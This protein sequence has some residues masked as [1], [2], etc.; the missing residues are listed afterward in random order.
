MTAIKTLAGAQ[1]TLDKEDM[2]KAIVF[3]IKTMNP[4][5]TGYALKQ[6]DGSG[7]FTGA[8]FVASPTFVTKGTPV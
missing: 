1:F 5:Y 6:L 7:G 8:V 2:E 4:D 3:Y